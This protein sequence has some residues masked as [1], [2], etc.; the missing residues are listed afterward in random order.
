MSYDFRMLE[1][2]MG[3]VYKIMKQIC[4]NTNYKVNPPV[5][6]KNGR[7]L[8][9]EEEQERRLT[10]HFTEVLNRLDPQH[11]ADIQLAEREIETSPA[12][13][14]ETK[15]AIATL[16]NNKVP[17][18]YSLCAEI[19]KTDPETSAEILQ[20]LFVEI[21]QPLFVEIL[22]PLFVEILQPLFVETLQPLFV[23]TLQPLFVEILHSLF[24][25][26]WEKEELPDDWT[27]M[28]GHSGG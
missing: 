19:F 4:G 15:A 26:M 3:I 27:L 14:A 17:G 5:M 6:D 1:D 22:Q 23:E 25:E 18:R 21:L 24:V 10:E 2:E 11:P 7:L 8:T 12:E 16:G 13:K 20:P 28:T 9:N